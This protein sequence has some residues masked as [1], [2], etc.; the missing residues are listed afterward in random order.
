MRSIIVFGDSIS[1]GSGA[2]SNLGW[3]SKLSQKFSSL[4]EHNIVYNQ[5]I[6]GDTSTNLVKR[7]KIELEARTEHYWPM[8][9]H[10]I[11]IAI[12]MNDI[13][14]NLKNKK[15][16]T[17]GDKFFR[18]VNKCVSY[19]KKYGDKV[20]VLGITPVDDKKTNPYEDYLYTNSRIKEYNAILKKVAIRQKVSFL[21]FHSDLIKD[22]FIKHLEDGIH[23]DDKGH[24]LI[25][26]KV[27][28]FLGI[29]S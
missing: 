11:I 1:Y 6:P 7:I 2:K 5:G 23:P 29:K 14:Q 18:N 4:G 17:N 27:I 15:L 24:E 22:G 28:L 3:V 9:Y 20:V 26:E 16:E 8:D 19:A 12:G 10:T 21:D 13:A 25:F